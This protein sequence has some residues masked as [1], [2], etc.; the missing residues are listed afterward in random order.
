[1]DE[2]QMVASGEGAAAPGQ[3]ADDM[4]ARLE[5]VSGTASD[6]ARDAL[7]SNS[8]QATL[9]E[10]KASATAEISEIEDL[11]AFGYKEALL[12]FARTKASSR[13]AEQLKQALAKID[14]DEAK[15]KQAAMARIELAAEPR[16][17]EGLMP[18]ASGLSKK[19]QRKARREQQDWLTKQEDYNSFKANELK[20]EVER[21]KNIYDPTRAAL[22]RDQDAAFVA[23][24]LQKYKKFVRDA[25]FHD[26][27]AWALRTADGH[28]DSAK[29][30]F[31]ACKDQA[32]LKK[33]GVWAVANGFGGPKL[34]AVL[35]AAADLHLDANKAQAVAPYLVDCPDPATRQWLETRAPTTSAEDLTFEVGR[36]KQHTVATLHVAT[37]AIDAAPGKPVLTNYNRLL[38]KPDLGVELLRLIRD[39]SIASPVVAKIVDV[40][41]DRGGRPEGLSQGYEPSADG[42]CGAAGDLCAGKDRPACEAG[43]RHRQRHIRHCGGCSPQR[44]ATLYRARPEAAR[45]RPHQG[46]NQGSRYRLHGMAAGLRK[47]MDGRRGVKQPIQSGRPELVD[48]RLQD[49]GRRRRHRG[50]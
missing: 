23:P 12:D 9:T 21:L 27:A 10:A 43:Q 17:P 24:E 8:C 33:F 31:D 32:E 49:E 4:E 19:D 50:S 28:V 13:G 42:L 14:A 44:G 38:A 11:K 26:D 7:E 39:S 6:L 3:S 16:K 29:I 30:L 40:Y 1:M 2:D 37:T 5:A 25:G 34:F 48:R 22:K 45:G 18:S 35:K 41:G 20:A 15:A 36:L 46:G 47:A